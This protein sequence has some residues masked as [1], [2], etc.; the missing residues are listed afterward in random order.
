VPTGS[1]RKNDSQNTCNH[2]GNPIK[3][4]ANYCAKCGKKIESKFNRPLKYKLLFWYDDEYGYR[5]S[6]TKLISIILFIIG[7]LVTIITFFTLISKRPRAA[8]RKIIR[9][10]SKEAN[11]ELANKIEELEKKSRGRFDKIDKK[12]LENDETNIAMLRNT[13][14]H[15]YFKYKDVKKIPHYEK[16]NLVSLYE[17]YE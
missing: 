6:K 12:N 15:I 9:E 17:R 4:N 16:E 3:N 14:T 11:K 13:I 2:C 8:L 1:E 5:L 10:E 7:A